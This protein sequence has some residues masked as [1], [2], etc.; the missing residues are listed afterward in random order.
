MISSVNFVCYCW[1]R[2]GR[3][4][5]TTWHY[6][7]STPTSDIDVPRPSDGSRQNQLIRRRRRWRSRPSL[8]VPCPC[9]AACVH[10]VCFSVIGAGSTVVNLVIPYRPGSAP[11]AMPSSLNSRPTSSFWLSTNARSWS[12]VISTSTPSAVMNQRLCDSSVQYWL[13]SKHTTNAS[14]HIPQTEARLM[15]T[16]MK[17]WATGRHIRPQPDP[18]KGVCQSWLSQTSPYRWRQ[19]MKD[20]RPQQ[21]PSC[22]AAVRSLWRRQ[23]PSLGWRILRPVRQCT[24][25]PVRWTHAGGKALGTRRWLF[26]TMLS[27]QT[28]GEMLPQVNLSCR[29]PGVAGGLARET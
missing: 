3:R 6:D 24:T 4:T 5:S 20:A 10:W 17:M 12:L 22:L 26:P 29:L 9:R 2:C 8:H 13:C 28:T 11:T 25:I 7:T 16:L 23:P 21:V 15:L 14:K 27:F 19:K 18:R 1:P